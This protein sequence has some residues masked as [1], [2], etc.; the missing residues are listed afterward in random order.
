MPERSP[1]SR[2]HAAEH[3]VSAALAGS[4]TLA[5]AGP[6]VLRALG[7]ALRG[8][9]AVLWT[10][11][12]PPAGAPLRAAVGEREPARGQKHAS[13]TAL[14]PEDGPAARAWA[15]G[16][17]VDTPDA[18]ALPIRV[19]GEVLGVLQLEG[20]IARPLDDAGL[21]TLEAIGD[22]VGLALERERA[23]LERERL[24]AREQAVRAMAEG[25][26]RRAALL[27]ELAR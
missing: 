4:A 9:P 3:G 13:G 15:A 12:D 27:G 14:T 1:A 17:R 10:G 24:L 23:G 7:E 11:G 19:R 8:R 18:L 22:R 20:P 16:V 25:E 26:T 21:Q 6:L 5:E 2:L